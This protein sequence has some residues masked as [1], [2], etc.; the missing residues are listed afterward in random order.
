[1][2]SKTASNVVNF[3]AKTVSPGE[4]KALWIIAIAPS[5]KDKY[6]CEYDQRL[7]DWCIRVQS[8]SFHGAEN[9]INKCRRSLVYMGMQER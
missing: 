1:M 7:Q 9:L 2:A 5:F 6:S 4:D 8:S 3:P